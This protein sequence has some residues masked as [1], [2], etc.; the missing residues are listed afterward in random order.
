MCKPQNLI[1]IHAMWK[2][3]APK[4]KKYFV[5]NVLQGPLC[6]LYAALSDSMHFSQFGRAWNSGK[7]WSFFSLVLQV[8]GLKKI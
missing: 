2:V 1:D 7:E 6:G 3:R 4:K 5:A 8:L